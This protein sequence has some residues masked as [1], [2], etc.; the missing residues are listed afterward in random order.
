MINGYTIDD[1]IDNLPATAKEKR[2][3][4]L[5]PTKN[6]IVQATAGAQTAKG[7]IMVEESN[8]VEQ[9][10]HQVEANMASAGEIPSQS[11]TNLHPH[12]L[13]YLRLPSL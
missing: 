5:G 3:A 2:E 10:P 1:I 12:H 11:Y 4:E 7:F 9:E 13:R 8:L 6:I